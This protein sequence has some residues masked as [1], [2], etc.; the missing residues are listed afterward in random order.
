[1][2]DVSGRRVLA[3]R[4]FKEEAVLACLVRSPPTLSS[5]SIKN[6]QMNVYGATR[7]LSHGCGCVLLLEFLLMLPDLLHVL[8]GADCQLLNSLFQMFAADA[9]S[10]ER[11]QSVPFVCSACDSLLE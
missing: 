10:A 2:H 9:E 3:L 5:Q 8:C 11:S 6:R 4:S 7:C 1:M